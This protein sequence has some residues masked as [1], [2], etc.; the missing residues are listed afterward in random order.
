M[1]PK[2][3]SEGQ[4]A[5]ERAD[6][7]RVRVEDLLMEVYTFT[8]DT[9]NGIQSRKFTLEELADL[10]FLCREIEKSVDET[11]KEARAR[12][13]LCGKVIAFVTAQA[14]VADPSKVVDS[15]RGRFSI[16]TPDVKQIPKI[17]QPGTPEYL[18][19]MAWLGITDRELLDSG[20]LSFKFQELCDLVTK[21]AQDAKNMPP[22]ITKTWPSFVCEFR[23]RKDKLA[24]PL[25]LSKLQRKKSEESNHEG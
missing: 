10:G 4:K 2:Q 3:L 7:L 17:P 24:E 9:L 22:G 12:K 8:A 5:I 25:A 21:R 14:R 20:V 13:E 23:R 16:A 6:E 1:P 19:L 18:Q 11:R 15:V